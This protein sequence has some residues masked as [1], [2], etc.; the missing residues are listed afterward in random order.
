MARA[1]A[2]NLRATSEPPPSHLGSTSTTLDT[3]RRTS[4]NLG[5]RSTRAGAASLSPSGA[6]PPSWPPGRRA[7]SCG[8][9]ARSSGVPSRRGGR[10][11]C[12]DSPPRC[13]RLEARRTLVAPGAEPPSKAGRRRRR[14]RRRW[15]GSWALPGGGGRCRR[16]GRSGLSGRRAQPSRGRLPS[17]CERGAAP[18]PPR[19]WHSGG[20]V[21]SASRRSLAP[22]PSRRAVCRRAGAPMRWP[23]GPLTRRCCALCTRVGLG[24]PSPRPA[25][26]LW[27]G[28]GGDVP[29]TCP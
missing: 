2:T 23:R 28:R 6:P 26:L 15:P 20:P 25:A 16:P 8:R 22:Q 4:A 27:L 5:G 1:Q 11:H 29:L 13:L 14:R 24:S 9:V 12:C 21:R 17:C 3:S 7:R 10:P 18:T 19:P